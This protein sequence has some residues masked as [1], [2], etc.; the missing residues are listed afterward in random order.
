MSD[1]MNTPLDQLPLNGAVNLLAH[2]EDGLVALEKP[3]GLMSHPN[4]PED[5]ERSLLTADYDLKEECY[6]WTDATGEIRRAWLINRLDSP[7]SGV[8]L[9]GLN[10]EITAVIKKEFSTHRVTKIYYALV[11]GRPQVPSGS[12][13]DKLKKVAKNGNCAQ[14]VP[15]KTRYQVIKS[16]TGGFPVS[17]LKLLPLTGRTHQLR[18]QCN[19]HGLPIVGDRT[20]GNFGFNKEVAIKV[21]TRRMM[22]HSAETIV[23]YC[24]KGQLRELTAKSELPEDFK[25]V[26][27]YRPGLNMHRPKGTRSQVLA[28]RRFKAPEAP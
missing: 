25:A 16:P 11:R 15:A 18:V 22:L 17:L 3:T 14:I 6:S 28:G 5:N 13:S 8:I 10:P 7:T 19:K 4:G 9:L 21:E 12:W 23:R 20:Y 26:M 1:L 24:Y 27:S 2:N